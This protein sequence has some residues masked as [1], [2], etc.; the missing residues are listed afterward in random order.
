M[1]ELL[2]RAIITEWQKVSQIRSVSF[3]DSQTVA[4]MSGVVILNECVVTNDYVH[5]KHCNLAR[6][7]AFIKLCCYIRFLLGH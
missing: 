5:V 3:I 7:A 2:K 6:I 1:A 4:S